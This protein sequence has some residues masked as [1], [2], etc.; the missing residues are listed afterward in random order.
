M[1]AAW[2]ARICSARSRGFGQV[3]LYLAAERQVI[4]RDQDGEPV[5]GAA[6]RAQPVGEMPRRALESSLAELD[7][8]EEIVHQRHVQQVLPPLPSGQLAGARFPQLAEGLLEH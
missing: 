1:P 6:G 5:G 4:E 7:L 3:T 8:A 2:P